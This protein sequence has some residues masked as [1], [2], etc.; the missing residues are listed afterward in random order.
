M[1]FAIRV[2]EF[3]GPEV[4]KYEEVTVGPPG[5]GEAKIRHTAIGLNFIDTYFRTGLYQPAGGLP[6]IPGNEAA[7]VVVEVGEGVSDLRPGDRV[8]YG[9]S[10]GSYCTERRIPAAALVKLPNT[11]P[12][13]TAAAMMLKGMTARYLLR[14]T[15]KVKPGDTIL[16]HAAAGGVGLILCQWAS[17]IGATV[18]GTAGSPEKVALA[19]ANG[20]AYVIDYSKD[21]FV[22]QVKEITDGALCDVVYDGVG[23]ATYPGSLDCI[24][25]R[26][27]FVSFG[28]ASGPITNFNLLSLSQ[29][30]SLYATRPTLNTHI[31]TRETLLATANDLFDVVGSGVVKIAVEQRYRLPDAAQAHRDLEARRTTGSTVLL[32]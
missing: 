7:G 20:A 19:K 15:H 6:F 3:G 27:L 9:A 4:L 31:A 32:P 8:A 10:T 17:H 23:Q 18:I 21:D 30:G 11:I 14:Q 1:A 5:P 16:V 12:D 13:E 28:N 2:H 26:G 22:A 29:K 24:R 25:P